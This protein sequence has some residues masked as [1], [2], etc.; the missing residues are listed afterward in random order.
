MVPFM[1]T[2]EIVGPASKAMDGADIS[3]FIGFIVG[4]A[5]YYPLRHLAA[6]PVMREGIE[7][8]VAAAT[9]AMG[10]VAIPSPAS[11]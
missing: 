10:D 6:Q 9:A 2:S 3:F 8:S 7:V 1:D 5:V 11:V 4:A